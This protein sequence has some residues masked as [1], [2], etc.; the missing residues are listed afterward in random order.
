VL[1]SVIDLGR[2]RAREVLLG[3]RHP[4]TEAR[5][6]AGA[7]TSFLRRMLMTRVLAASV[8]RRGKGGK[9]DRAGA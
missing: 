5:G 8:A 6:E 9:S 7:V 2:L 3:E 4:E 1:R